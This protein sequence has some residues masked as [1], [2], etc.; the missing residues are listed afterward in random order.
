MVRTELPYTYVVKGRY[1]RFRRAGVDTALPGRPG[2]AAFHRRYGELMDKAEARQPQVSRDTFAWLIAHYLR[3]PEFKALAAPTQ[4]DYAAT[5]E[6]L[7]EKLGDVRFAHATRRIIKSVR[8]DFAGTPRKAHK[9]KQMVS[10]LYTYAQECDLVDGDFNPAAG[11]KKISRRSREFV[12]WSDAEIDLFLSK[13]QACVKTPVIIG[14]YTGQRANDVARMTWA[15]VQGDVIRVRQS[16]TGEMLDIACHPALRAYLDEL[17]RVL[18]NDGTRR[19]QICQTATGNAFD[20]NSLS[21]AVYR[22]IRAIDGMPRDRSFHG[23]RYAAG[24]RLDEAGCTVS[25]IESVL[26][27]RTFRMALKY[28]SQRLRS[29]AAIAKIEA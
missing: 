2:D 5:C 23:L 1:W 11:I 3:S 29:K 21:S 25:Q 4:K 18:D 13:A 9:I 27:H 19:I 6:T 7:K 8:D 10:R 24:S 12:V 14:V 20:S 22:E 26:G 16:K 15:D 28:A 17:R